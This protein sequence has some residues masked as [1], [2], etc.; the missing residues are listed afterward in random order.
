VTQVWAHRGKLGGEKSEGL[1]KKLTE[2]VF[3]A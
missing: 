3:G 1:G 2:L